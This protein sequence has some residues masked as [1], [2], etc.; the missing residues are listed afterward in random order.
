[1]FVMCSCSEHFAE[2]TRL[3]CFLWCFLRRL[4]GPGGRCIRPARS[5]DFSV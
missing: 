5:S 3:W 4:S 2:W 1:M